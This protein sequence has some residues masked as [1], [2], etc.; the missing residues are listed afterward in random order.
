MPDAD[1]SLAI[2]GVFFGS[3]GTA[4]QRCTSTRRL[5]LHREIATEFLEKL[6]KLYTSIKPGD[7]LTADTLLGPMHNKAAVSVYDGTIKHLHS[8]NAEVLCGGKRFDEA[9]FSAGNF[10]RPTLAVPSSVDMKDKIWST[11]TFA[12]I[13]NAAVFDDLEQAIEWNNAVP[14]VRCFL[15]A[16]GN[17]KG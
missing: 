16:I 8:I 17:N 1:M 2:P 4:G 10:V 7:P 5:F 6:R 13:L 9:P 15:A 3:V 11:E 12:P 14:Q